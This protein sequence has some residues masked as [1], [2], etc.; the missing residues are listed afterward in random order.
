MRPDVLA[1]VS[2]MTVPGVPLLAP[3]DDLAAAVGDAIERSGVGLAAFDVVVIASKL[4]SRAEGRIVPIS[5]AAPSERAYAIAAVTGADPAL[6]EWV[7]RESERVS[8]VARGVLITR[9]RLGHV[10]ANAA[11]DQSN[12]APDRAGWIA[13]LPTDPDQSAR[14]VRAALQARFG[15]DPVGVIVTDSLGRPF[16]LGTVGAAIGVSGLPALC[17]HRGTNDLFGRTLEHTETALADQI[18]AA[19]DLLAGQAADA[20]GVTRVR[21]VRWPVTDADPGVAPLLRDPDRDLFLG[22]WP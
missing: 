15:V 17:D 4:V 9:H 14:R 13:L 11:I 3:G 10:S 2:L 12:V 16:R 1:T 6:T 20:R 5:D 7:L 22:K 19:A 21:G 18:A 8:R